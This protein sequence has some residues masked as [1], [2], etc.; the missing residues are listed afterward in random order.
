MSVIQDDV[1]AQSIPATAPVGRRGVFVVAAFTARRLAARLSLLAVLFVLVLDGEAQTP[2][3]GA[4]YYGK[5]STIIGPRPALVTPP[6]TA[7]SALSNTVV[8]FEVI[9]GT[10]ALGVMDVELFDQEKPA[11]VRNFLLYV[12]S[13]A[14]SNSFIHRNVPGF[15][16]QGGGFTVDDPAKTNLFSAY[17]SVSEFGK[18]TNEF[19]VGSRMSNTFATISMAKLGG[20][21][22]SASSQWF[23][24]LG[25]NTTNL[26]NQNG[27]F[28]VFGRV[29][30]S[31]NAT[32]GT[33]VLTHF[34][35]RSTNSTI[36]N[37]GNL[38]SSA[39]SVFSDLP[40]AVS[41]TPPRV[42]AYT[43]LYYTRVSVL[44]DSYVAG[45]NIP[46]IA[47]TSPA[48]DSRF[49][50]Q[51]VTIS[52]TAADD[53]EIAQ[54]VYRVNGGAPQIASGTTNW[55]VHLAPNLGLTTVS[56]ESIDFEG[57]RSTNAPSVSFFY[58]ANVALS[59]QVNGDGKV[60]GV[61]NGQRLEL[62]RYYTA[63]AIPASK[64]V[65]ETWSGSVTS[66]AAALTFLV[67]TNATNFSLSARFVTHPFIRLAGTYHGIIR[68]NNPALENSGLMTLS[69]GK[70]GGVSGR[71]R[72]RGGNY[73]FTGK[74]DTNYSV[75]LQ[76]SVGGIN[77]S[78]SL[79]LDTTNTA[80]VITGSV[81][82]NTTAEVVLERLATSLPS[83]NVPP[84]GSLTFAI[85]DTNAFSQLT[86]GG[87]GYGIGKI[88]RSGLLNLSGTLGNG[89]T[90][91][92]S[93]KLTRQNRWPVYHSLPRGLAVFEGWLAPATNQTSYLDG[94][95]QWIA[96]ADSKAANYRAGFTNQPTLQASPFVPP[97][98]GARVMN[99]VNG[100]SRI[101]GANLVRGVTNIVKLSTNNTIGI[102]D[103]NTTIF[104][105]SLDLRSGEVRGSFV[106]PWVGTTNTLRG[107]ILKRAEGIRGLFMDGEQT[108]GL[109][110]NVSPFL[111]TQS[112]ANV[113]LAGFTEALK[114]GGILRFEGDGVITL[115]NTIVPAYDTALDANG[116][117]V[118]IDG[119]GA[120][121]LF[122]V[123]TNV[124]FAATGVTLANGRFDGTNGASTSPPQPGGDGCGA[125]ILNLGGT[126]GLTNCVLTNF[127]VTGGSPGVVTATNVAA[128]A[129]GRGLGAALCNL[130]GRVALQS[131]RL[132]NNAAFGSPT[133]TNLLAGLVVTNSGAAMGGAIYSEGGECE[134]R[135][136]TLENNEARG[137]ESVGASGG[138]FSQSG[139]ASGG[140]IAIQAGR[141]QLISSTLTNNLALAAGSPTN[142]AG[143]GGAYGGALFVRS[144]AQAV[145]EQTVLSGNTAQTDGDSTARA[146]DSWGGAI[147][148]EGQL[149]ILESTLADNAAIGGS[150][151][152]TGAGLGGAVASA[153]AA[154][155]MASTFSGNLAQGGDGEGGETNGVAGGRGL[156]GAIHSFGG[157]LFMTNST[158]ALNQ[159][160]GGSG[161]VNAVTNAGPRGDA[162]GGAVSVISNTAVLVHVTIAYNE[163]I[164][165]SAGDTNTGTASGG[166][167]VNSGG[168]FSLRASIVATNSTGNFSGDIVDLGYNLS[169][170]NS[171][172]L[173]VST[174]STNIEPRLGL[175]T[176]NGGPTKTIALRTGS[177]ALD[178][179]P[180]TGLPATD[181]RG[182]TRPA[183]IIG[184]SGAFESTD[185]QVPPTFVLQ[186]VGTV[187]RA[188]SNY[189]F[190][191][192]ATGPAPIGYF[193][194]KNGSV[195]NGATTTSYT[196]N[197]L[198]DFD[199]ANYVAV[200]T[201]AFGSTTSVV[202]A[203]TVDS[204]PLLIGEPADASVAPGGPANF[205]VS[206]NG[207]SLRYAW[208]KNGS[209]IA[210]GTNS[211]LTISNVVLGSEGSY[212]VIVTN[213][214]GSVT[215]RVA[216][217]TFNSVALNI[218]AQPLSLSVTQGQVASFSVLA[219]GVPTITYQWFFGSLPIAD[220]TNSTLTFSS[221]DLTNTGN[222]RVIVTNDYLSLVSTSATLN[223]V[224]PSALAPT[225]IVAAA[226]S[227]LEITCQARPGETYQLLCATNF[228]AAAEWREVATSK[229]PA[230]GRLKWI[231]P[232][233]ASGPLYFRAVTVK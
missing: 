179:V 111:L 184:D 139:D 43:G 185:T 55:S 75:T 2:K 171:V 221:V 37:L 149:R 188:G 94:A 141:L 67:P 175:L 68:S 27:G 73:S 51:V 109:S 195:I 176:T 158:I 128:A 78:I 5:I 77:R 159:V 166:G 22:D 129:S 29:L 156:G 223:V 187:V 180:T 90:F 18:L 130:G 177:P 163:T 224:L 117:N 25:N 155:S 131:S 154:T 181:Q 168:A 210:G 44:N 60:T 70:R 114:E 46:T 191:A 165:G 229:M 54:V 64:R 116:H 204:R 211:T 85:V 178:I 174:S 201:N 91:K 182:V 110:V 95:M 74:F 123:R 164:L 169:S 172:A 21:P 216:A 228:A 98:S 194:M 138:D 42:P 66:T 79:K 233:P 220:A 84:V 106:H 40:V 202:A 115:T 135:S 71:V 137:G 59:L 227:N 225:L 81:F 157:T 104:N 196:L 8:R 142:S 206:V 38:I 215:S 213:F 16:A 207:P 173:T 153:G 140:A 197:N 203:L 112:V 86:P 150:G 214:A 92:T 34:N 121:R 108:G 14:Y 7:A 208:F 189:T 1:G 118:V 97:A 69:L 167:V 82:G 50:N 88:S 193:W 152:L 144:N 57:R 76:G 49:T 15:A 56:V 212:Q 190:Q 99:W 36:A 26:D 80:G 200:A 222:Y 28:T 41:N 170:D 147:Y 217:L 186:P 45:T 20:D 209:P 93:A 87:S 53:G 122:E 32:D 52:G 143:V 124:G 63:T 126:I 183:G 219:S 48:P 230:S 102:L 148:N 232:A 23:F 218:V 31:T 133:T 83:T 35:S 113:T 72:H 105:L 146:G 17:N 58:A 198:Q 160:R 65:L 119:A 199:T 145:V 10:N 47:I 161:A 24:N 9:R 125:G 30:E 61:T 89:A 13:G 162:R 136:S 62:G 103:S 11:T 6:F 134:I 192:I 4:S 100:Q 33:N 19:L 107:V 205:V 120:H 96:P 3:E 226:G 127:I 12:R 39:Y 132:V 101:A 151:Y 231:H